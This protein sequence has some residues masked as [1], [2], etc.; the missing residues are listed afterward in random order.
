[1]IRPAIHSDVPRLVELA[2]LLHA[3]SDYSKKSFCSDKTGAFLH[4][5]I[6]GQGVIFVSEMDGEVIG[7]LAGAVIDQWFSNDLIAYD[8]SLFTDPSTRSG[9]TAKRLLRTFKEW[10]RI[11][12]AVEIY[13][14]IGT[15]VNVEGTTR[16]YE[17]EGFHQIGPLLMM[18][19]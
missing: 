12:G 17:S 10:A 1:M 8:Y 18:E 11:K 4:T 2:I 7:G 3:T 19:I 5:L 15:G 6:N 14:G 13:M 9:V 16:L